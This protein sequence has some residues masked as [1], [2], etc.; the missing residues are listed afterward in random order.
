MKTEYIDQIYDDFNLKLETVLKYLDVVKDKTLKTSE[1]LI[2]YIKLYEE[3]F[4]TLTS[5]SKNISPGDTPFALGD[6]EKST[7]TQSSNI[8]DLS[9]KIAMNTPLIE[10]K[11]E[12]LLKNLQTTTQAFQNFQ[13]ISNRVIEA[14][15][16]AISLLSPNS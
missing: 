14:W 13:T 5:T 4:S 2:D 3:M 7:T 10:Y 11:F 1:D 6:S 9:N 16:E 12:D 15:E 8:S